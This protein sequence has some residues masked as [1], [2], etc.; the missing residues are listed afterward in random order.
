M[1]YNEDLKQTDGP[2]GTTKI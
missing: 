1:L 2:C